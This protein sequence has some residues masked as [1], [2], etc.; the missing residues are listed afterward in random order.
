MEASAGSQDEIIAALR[1]ELQAE[2][3]KSE[4]VTTELEKFRKKN[5]ELV[6]RPFPA[7]VPVSLMISV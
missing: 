3:Q 1:S 7:G 5:V 6:T 4:L 2:K